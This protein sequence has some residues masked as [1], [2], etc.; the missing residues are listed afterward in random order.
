MKLLSCAALLTAMVMP[1]FGLDP[2][3]AK[4]VSGEAKQLSGTRVDRA[5]AS[6]LGLFILTQASVE[7]K[8]LDEFT[9]KTGFDF[10]RD[11]QDVVMAANNGRGDL[12]A[13]RGTFKGELIGSF[14][15]AAGGEKATYA[16]VDIYHADKRHG[17]WFAFPEAGIGLLGEL[18]SIKAAL[19]R[20]TQVTNIDPKLLVKAEA[21]SSKYDVWFAGSAP[22]QIGLGKGLVKPDGIELVSGG[23][24]LGSTI[25]LNAE[26][27]MKTEKDAI[28]LQQTI[29]FVLTMLQAQGQKTM[30]LPLISNTQTKVEGATVTFSGSVLEADVEKLFSQPRRIAAIR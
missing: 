24:N 7:L 15:L 28:G 11:I 10:R 17:P 4:Y 19:D 8:Q 23:L 13:A 5:L 18:D 26:A 12:A 21:S 20:R 6:P 3:L 1:S 16:G 29:Q 9:A 25:E 30:F 27:V 14:V 22:T 2:A